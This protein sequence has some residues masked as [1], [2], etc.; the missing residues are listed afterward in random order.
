MA[1]LRRNFTLMVAGRVVYALSQWLLLILLARLSSAEL[2][3]HFTYALA[4]TGPIIVF[5]QLN[6]RAYMATDAA[7]RYGFSDYLLTRFFTLTIAL[8]AIG[9]IVLATGLQGIAAT[10]LILVGLYKAIEALSDLFYGVMQKRERMAPIARSVS[11]RGL[12]ALLA[13][14]LALTTGNGIVLGTL[15]ITL[16]W[17]GVL[18]FHDLPSARRLLEPSQPEGTPHPA[19]RP[20]IWSLGLTCLPMG[21]VVTLMSLRINIP[22]YFIR[23]LLGSEAVGHYS[24]VAYFLVAGALVS[25][26]LAQASS[27]RLAR[28]LHEG[29]RSEFLGLL[30]KL[31]GL[32]SLVGLTGVLAASLLGGEI[33]RLVYGEGYE[34]LQG[35][36][37]VIMLAAA[38]N[39][40]AQL[41]GMSLTVARLLWFQLLANGLATL[42][43]TVLAYLLVP[44][45][46]LI[47][48]G[49]AL[50]SGIASALACNAAALV[51]VLRKILPTPA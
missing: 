34:Q 14:S 24:A 5:S 35:L 43:V 12:L 23:H 16:G 44:S 29:R 9:A 13:M 33:L 20:H 8:A 41:I 11:T 4:V 25:G 30:Y 18:L 42:V 1:S 51:L 27:P 45:Q 21:F 47:G 22:T 32:S 15:G 7:N 38:I 6:M 17:L 2:L 46:G 49:I 26:S 31:L 40:L 10:L 37:V 39:Y 3:G 28:L 48:G 50:L 36:L 19:A